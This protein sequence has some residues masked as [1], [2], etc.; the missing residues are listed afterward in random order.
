MFRSEVFWLGVIVAFAC[1]VFI[2]G[3]LFP[4]ATDS[5]TS[6]EAARMLFVGDVM[7]ARHVETL[8]DTEGA[9][10]PFRGVRDFFGEAVAVVGNFEGA[11]PPRHVQTPNG[12]M[13]FSVDAEIAP[14]LA[15]TGFTHLSLANNHADDY[16][17]TGYHNTRAVLARAGMV[18]AGHPYELTT[19]DI[20]YQELDGRV[21]ALVPLYAVSGAP[22]EAALETMLVEATRASDLQVVFVHWGEE[23]ALTASQAQ[24]SLAHTLVDLGAD[25]VIGHHPHVVQ[26]VEV[27]RNAPVF[28]SLGN[29]IF[30]Q[31]WRSEVEEGLMVALSFTDAHVRYELLPVTS[32]ETPSAPR[33]MKR[34]ERTQFLNGLANRSEESLRDELRAGVIERPVF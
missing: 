26:D 23:Y 13:R 17:E 7:L 16:G 15:R 11:I 12:A 22:D 30:D 33:P 21:V 32:T 31:Y 2:G 34:V 1:L 9:Y 28:Y 20:L 5:D 27:Y 6:S 19:D 8:M 29:F 14:V 18:A 10:Y 24:R 3:R 4:D 25:A